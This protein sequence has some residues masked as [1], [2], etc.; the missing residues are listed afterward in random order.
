MAPL[1]DQEPLNPNREAQNAE[2]REVEAIPAHPPDFTRKS[3]NQ[4]QRARRP[5]ILAGMRTRG[6]TAKREALKPQNREAQN[7]EPREDEAIPALNSKG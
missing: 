1:F 6:S 4:V 5:Q 3:G 7:A 2:P